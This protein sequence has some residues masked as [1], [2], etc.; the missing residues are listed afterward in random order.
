[1]KQLQPVYILFFPKFQ[2]TLTPDLGANKKGDRPE[3]KM[4]TTQP[5]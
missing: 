4:K 5:V 3:V 1:M 2:A